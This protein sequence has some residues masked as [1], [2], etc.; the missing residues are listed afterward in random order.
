MNLIN[1]PGRFASIVIVTGKIKEEVFFNPYRFGFEY[2]FIAFPGNKGKKKGF[3]LNRPL[4]RLCKHTESH[5]GKDVGN[6]KK[7][8][9]NSDKAE[10]NDGIFNFG[11]Q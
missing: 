9:S 10:G 2:L 7:W 11:L 3:C 8:K 6:Q 1:K 5:K 4:Y